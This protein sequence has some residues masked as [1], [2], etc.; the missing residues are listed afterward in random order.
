MIV[1]DTNVLSELIKP[2]P[3]AAVLAWLDAQLDDE[4]WTTAVT[5][6][7]VRFGLSVLPDGRRR[8]ALTEAYEQVLHED[9][10]G[11][12][13]DLDPGAASEAARIAGALRDM[14]RPVEIQDVLIA[15]SVG[16]R[17]GTL[18]TRNIKHFADTGIPLIDPW[19]FVP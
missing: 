10:A 13:I 9:L 8:R 2:T 11:R 19:T 16:S 18:A 17:R 14:G 12:I 3:D 5:V 1:L 4:V 6:F 7:E 15:G